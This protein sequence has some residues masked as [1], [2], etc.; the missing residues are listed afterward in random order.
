MQ[1]MLKQIK[2]IIINKKF[3]TLAIETIIIEF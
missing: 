1:K 3:P 2:T